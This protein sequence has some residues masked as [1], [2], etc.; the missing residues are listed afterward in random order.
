MGPRESGE[1]AA[2]VQEG[3]MKVII[4]C[5]FTQAVAVHTLRQHGE[6]TMNWTSAVAHTVRLLSS[7]EIFMEQAWRVICP[8]S[9]MS[10]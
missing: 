6:P 3:C 5:E 7:K 4:L 9:A 10:Y 1:N 2:V 8:R